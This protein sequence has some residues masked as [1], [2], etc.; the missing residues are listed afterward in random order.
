MSRNAK[1]SEDASSGMLE[2]SRIL[3]VRT[4]YKTILFVLRSYDLLI[5]G[6]IFCLLVHDRFVSFQY[7]R[8]IEPGRTMI[9]AVLCYSLHIWGA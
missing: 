4:G 8:P 2:S 7:L 9:S 1:A 5:L 6:G 3:F